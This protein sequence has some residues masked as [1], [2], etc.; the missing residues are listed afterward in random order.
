MA[1]VVL[2]ADGVVVRGRGH[3][4]EQRAAR[5]ARAQGARPARGGARRH[6]GSSRSWRGASATTGATRPPRRSGTS[7]A[8]SRR[9]TRGMSY[10]R[11]EALG[12]IQ[13]PCPDDEHPGSL[14]PPRAAVGR[15][16]SSGPLAPFSVVEARA[17]VRG[18]RR[19]LPDPAH[20]RAA[21][22]L[23]QHG[24]AVEPATARR[25]TAARRST[26]RPRTRSVSRSPTGE[27]VRV[28]SRRGAVEAPVRIDPSLRAGLA[29]MTFHFP[30][31]VDDEPAHDRRHR[32]EVRHGG[33]QGRRDPRREAGARC[34]CTRR[35]RTGDCSRLMDLKLVPHAEPT[36]S[37]RAALDAVLGPPGSG[38]EGGA[39]RP[40]PTG[41]PPPAATRRA[42]A[43]TC[44]CPRCRRCRSAS[45]G[46][47][48]AG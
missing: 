12:G 26:S 38:W 35:R 5:A 10:D 11:L 39:R 21:P 22:R 29:F 3:G 19:R 30:D 25:S 17:A 15:R 44:C 40:A 43:A 42:R 14:V 36:A 16:P 20:D 27:V 24:R 2:P 7:C 18:A 13:W 32:P 45:A 6:R 23:V 8:R 34:A 9:C 33:V 1:D 47:A 41:T 31:E 37:E 46:S 28:S 48:P 4:D